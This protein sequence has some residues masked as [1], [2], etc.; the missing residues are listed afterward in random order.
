[1]PEEKKPAPEMKKE[2][3]ETA[4]ERPA[5]TKFYFPKYNIYCEMKEK[6]V[7]K[8]IDNIGK[9]H[10]PLIIDEI[11]EEGNMKLYKTERYSIRMS[12]CKPINPFEKTPLK[13]KVDEFTINFDLDKSKEL[14][15]DDPT[16]DN[17][18][19]DAMAQSREKSLQIL[20][21]QTK[22]ILNQEAKAKQIQ[23]LNSRLVE[24]KKIRA[25]LQQKLQTSSLEYKKEGK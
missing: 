16:I 6:E 9:S 11:D 14:T 21:E 13:L 2:P 5:E 20:M 15:F 23:S 19:K 10:L 24:L 25:D 7:K 22:F 17:K 3:T 1:M 4:V 8:A 18:M 12:N